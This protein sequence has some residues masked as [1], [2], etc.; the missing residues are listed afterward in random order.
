[1]NTNV[2]KSSSLQGKMM[3]ILVVALFALS[4][5][6]AMVSASDDVD[7]EKE[8][9][10]GI[11]LGE[12]LVSESEGEIE[13]LSESD[14]VSDYDGRDLPI[15]VNMADGKFSPGR[16]ESGSAKVLLVDDD[17]ETRMSGPYLEASHVATAL[18]DGGYAYDVFRAG[19]W[20]GVNKELPSG[21][22]GLSIIDDYEAIVWYGGWNTNLISSNEQAILEDYLDGDCG[23]ADN[24]CSDGRLV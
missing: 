20:N 6:S 17:Q 5:F 8:I 22:T 15:V 24:T 1:M 4:S 3:A 13:I 21:N 2:S 16:L 14:Q 10:S 23:T 9:I 18:N 12:A 11:T 7:E 19:N